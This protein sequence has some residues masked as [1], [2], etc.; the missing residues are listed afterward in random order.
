MHQIADT[1]IGDAE[2]A[3]R[4]AGKPAA[5]VMSW[6]DTV[7][8]PVTSGDS[9]ASR[10]KAKKFSGIGGKGGCAEFL[11]QDWAVVNGT[12]GQGQPTNLFLHWDEPRGPCSSC[13]SWLPKWQQANGAPLTVYWKNVSGDIIRWEVNVSW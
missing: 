2:Q 13:N 9:I 5:V 12:E 10:F 7:Y 3:A 1:L 4:D 11:C 8:E 6:G